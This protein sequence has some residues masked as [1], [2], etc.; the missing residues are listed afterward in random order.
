[1]T[2]H[3]R[4]ISCPDRYFLI[5]ATA[6]IPPGNKV[7]NVGLCTRKSKNL[8]AVTAQAKNGTVTARV[9]FIVKRLIVFT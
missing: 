6:P 8:L 5:I 3:A 1:L 9:N 7:F 2:Y 4:D